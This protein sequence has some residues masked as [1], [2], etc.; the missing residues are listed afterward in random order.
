MAGNSAIMWCELCRCGWLWFSPS[1]EDNFSCHGEH[2]HLFTSHHSAYHWRC[3]PVPTWEPFEARA[4][5][6]SDT[7][8]LKV[9]VE[10]LK[11]HF[12]TWSLH[13]KRAVLQLIEKFFNLCPG[14]QLPG[15]PCS[16]S[17]SDIKNMGEKY[18]QFGERKKY[19]AKSP[20]SSLYLFISCVWIFIFFDWRM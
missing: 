9:L 19:E 11:E 6:P 1:T 5:K 10:L 4:Y 3:Q 12:Q 15:L 2:S 7:Q 16:C 17:A 18:D 13:Q 14:I 20:V 8:T